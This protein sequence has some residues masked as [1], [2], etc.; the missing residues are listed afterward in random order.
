MRNFFKLI[1]EALLLWFNRGSEVMAAAVSYYAVFALVPLIFTSVYVVSLFFGED[2]VTK[3]ML[4]WGSSMGT[5]VLTL[6]K[7]AVNELPNSPILSLA[8]IGSCV[9]LFLAVLVFFN[10]L[11]E[12]FHR[13]WDYPPSGIE[14]LFRK[15]LRALFCIFL[16]QFFIAAL[17]AA[18]FGFALF[19]DE[20]EGRAYATFFVYIAAL[21]V[22]F[23]LCYSILP[24]GNLPSLG[25]RF[26]GAFIAAVLFSLAKTMV[27]IHIALT[28][29]P[30]LF[31]GAGVA[32]ILLLWVYVS[33]SFIYFGAAFAKVHDVERNKTK[34]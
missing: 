6:L 19:F 18:E 23:T 3:V 31:G 1:N 9:F 14:G 30:G 26:Y 24:L 21:T 13:L 17:I 28:P 10:T 20:L 15:F 12:G 27:S 32:L 2:L 8:P 25:S 5:G 11:T 4:S 29:V 22:L 33:A 16:L 34:I 7:T